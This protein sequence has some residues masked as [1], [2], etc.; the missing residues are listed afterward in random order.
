MKVK[1]VQPKTKSDFNGTPDDV[2]KS[3]KVI[4]LIKGSKLKHNIF[5]GWVEYPVYKEL[6]ELD[7]KLFKDYNKSDMVYIYAPS[8]GRS[9]NMGIL[10]Y[11]VVGA[12]KKKSDKRI[13]LIVEDMDKKANFKRVY[14]EIIDDSAIECGHVFNSTDENYNTVNIGDEYKGYR[15]S[16]WVKMDPNE[17]K[18]KFGKIYKNKK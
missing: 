6:S 2:I 10:S 4:H 13:L 11:K 18:D 12:T 3:T 9:D 5:S 15:N 14:L 17:F 7:P 1:T 16:K 8:H